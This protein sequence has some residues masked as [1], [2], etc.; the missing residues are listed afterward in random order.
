MADDKARILLDE[1]WPTLWEDARGVSIAVW[2][3]AIPQSYS[4]CASGTKLDGFPA[5]PRGKTLHRVSAGR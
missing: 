5:F 4:D 2:G 1:N 3:S